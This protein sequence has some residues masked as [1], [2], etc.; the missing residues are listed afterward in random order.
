MKRT[1]LVLALAAASLLACGTAWAEDAEEAPKRARRKRPAGKA[2][3]PRVNRE[4]A[5]MVKA[6][7]LTQEQQQQ[8]AEISAAGAKAGREWQKA[9]G[10][11]L[12]A[13][14]AE[15]A[16]ARKAKDKEAM[17]QAGEKMKTLTVE[18]AEIA[19]K[20]NADVLA[21]LSVEQRAAWQTH[22]DVQA[23]VRPM[24]RAK[25]TPEQMAKVKEI[26]AGG[27]KDVDRK[28][29]KAVGAAMKKIA[30]TIRTEVLT[31]EQREALKKPKA[32]P[33]L[34]AEKKLRQKKA[35]EAESD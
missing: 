6:C 27:L 16:A 14:R 11:E 12:K 32:E 17:K 19:S 21:V 35:R 34:R 7:E 18:R 33:K 13:L 25:L 8:I 3:K 29:K 23:A 22:L 9:H 4:L 10:E 1:A 30:A 26:V 2:K 15:M 20:T 5:A 28:D 24:R 31:D